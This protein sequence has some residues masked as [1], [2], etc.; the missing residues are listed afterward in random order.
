MKIISKYNLLLTPLHS[1]CPSVSNICTEEELDSKYRSLDG[2]CN[3]IYDGLRGKA[4]TGYKRLL[5]AAYLDGVQEIRR[6]VNR[7]FALP[8]PRLI[9]TSL[10]RHRNNIDNELT[11][12]VMQWSQFIEHDL[13]HTATSK[14]SKSYHNNFIF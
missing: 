5:P 9:S 11:L 8:S 13:A 12:S 2:S 7:K 6:S 3:N 14:M 1:A 4:F 10:C